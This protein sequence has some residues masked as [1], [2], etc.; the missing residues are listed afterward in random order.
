ME[1][2]LKTEQK[3]TLSHK[4]IQS[5]TILQMTSAQLEDYLSEQALENPLLELVP[6]Q[7]EEPDA[8]LLETYQWISSHDEQN[9]YLY[10]HMEASDEEPAEWSLPQTASESLADYLWEQLLTRSW[11]SH[12][13]NA[14]RY[15]LDSL[16]EKGYYP[17]SLDD[18]A[19]R[20]Q[21]TGDDAREILALIQSLEPAGIGA[22][23]LEECLCLQLGRQGL[24]TPELQ[25]F[26]ETNLPLIAKNQLSAIARSTRR[27]MAVI[28][29]WCA[30]IKGL[31]PKPGSAFSDTLQTSYIMPD[32]I[33]IQSGN[34]PQLWLNDTTLPNLTL[35]REYLD[36]FQ[37]HQ[38]KEVHDYLNQKLQQAQWLRQCIRQRNTTLMSVAQ[39]ILLLQQEFFSRGPDYLKPL[40]QSDVAGFLNIHVSTVSRAC[41]Q[42]YLQCVYGTF[43]F[44]YFFPKAASRTAPVSNGSATDDTRTT[45]ES[46][47][48][49]TG[50]PLAQT[51]PDTTTSLDV[52]KALA[53]II[54]Q[55]NTAKPY[56][57]RILAELLT[58]QGFHVSRRTVAKY[59]E[60]LSIPGTSGRKTY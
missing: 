13:E 38:D 34:R 56:S 22:R 59:R 1:Y 43:P 35:N 36:M 26:I 45:S 14:L 30:L 47:L 32:V 40:K 20:F 33:V 4:M 7:P 19:G 42:K 2:T 9:R 23:T 41:S 29:S 8:K 16:D 60:E 48:P 15:L 3:Q 46:D 17:D 31:N 49:A 12:W 5:S 18:F 25:E 58:D 53:S 37:E 21:L 24:L 55:E 54:R 52:K 51:E 27:S 11:P 57:D 39:T 50:K 28:K 44:S 6:R 10:S